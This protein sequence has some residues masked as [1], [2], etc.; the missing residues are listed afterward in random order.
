MTIIHIP[1]PVGGLGYHL[2]HRKNYF[3]VTLDYLK[4]ILDGFAKSD[5]KCLTGTRICQNI[6][7]N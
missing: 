6:I 2:I 7:I 3:N 1:T 5:K 4:R